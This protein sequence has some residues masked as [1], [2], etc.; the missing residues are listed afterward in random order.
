MRSFSSIIFLI[1]LML[2]SF[3]KASLPPVLS[4]E[5]IEFVSIKENELLGLNKVKEFIGIIGRLKLAESPAKQV[6]VYSFNDMTELKSDLRLC[7]NIADRIY[8]N[9]KE[10][11]LKR[12]KA[13]INSSSS[14]GEICSLVLV[15]PGSHARIKERHLFVKVLHAKVY[16]FVFRFTKGP[17]AEEIQDIRHFVEGLR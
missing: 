1:G 5:E 13:K 16:A 6:E 2:A 10:I 15:D 9:E 12:T 17:K 11:T 7:S 14:A 3:A 8:G 4:K